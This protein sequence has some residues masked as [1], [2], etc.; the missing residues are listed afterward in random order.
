M[1]DGPKFEFDSFISRRMERAI[2]HH[3]DSV[4]RILSIK[5]Y[6]YNRCCERTMSRRILL[7]QRDGRHALLAFLLVVAAPLLLVG[8]ASTAAFVAVRSVHFHHNENSVDCRSRHKLGMRLFQSSSSSSNPKSS[9]LDQLPG[10]SDSAFFRRISA[11]ASDP[12]TFER[13]V[14]Q[15]QQQRENNNFSSPTSAKSSDTDHFSQNENNNGAA[16][17]GSAQKKKGYVRAEEWDAEEQ[18]RRKSG[19]LTW[20]ERVQ[21]EGQLHGNR[22]QQND[23]LRHHLHK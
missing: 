23:I 14:M 11:A 3:G 20:E 6:N 10:E 21:F 13:A 9:F 1:G 5:L 2:D 16:N 19:E 4:G 8:V 12:A 17:E 15:D 22:V 7:R 18:R